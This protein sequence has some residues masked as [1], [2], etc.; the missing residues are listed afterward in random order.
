MQAQKH[1]PDI[2]VMDISMP[3]LNGLEAIRM[4]CKVLPKVRIAIFSL[5][6]SDDLVREAVESGAA[7]IY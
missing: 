2:A 7:L 3:E 5:H 6:Y 1:R 4:I